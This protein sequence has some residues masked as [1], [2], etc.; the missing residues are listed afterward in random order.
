MSKFEQMKRDTEAQVAAMPAYA[1][2]HVPGGMGLASIAKALG[3]KIAD[4][5]RG[6]TGED[7]STYVRVPLNRQD[8]CF[9]EP[10]RA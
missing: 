5:R 4:E 8:K 1:M 6:P 7:C 3:D 9:Q 10:Q 2:P